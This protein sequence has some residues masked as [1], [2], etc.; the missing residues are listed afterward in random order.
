MQQIIAPAESEIIR[1]RARQHQ[2]RSDVDHESR[3]AIDGSGAVIIAHFIISSFIVSS[4]LL[5]DLPEGRRKIGNGKWIYLVDIT[6]AMQ[7][8]GN[9]EKNIC[10][11]FNSF[12]RFGSYEQTRV[13]SCEPVST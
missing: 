13:H 10:C 7:R 12:V 9:T 5:I 8:L 1:Q 2:R 4:G 3:V 11:Q 6:R